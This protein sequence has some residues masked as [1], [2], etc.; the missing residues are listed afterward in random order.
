MAARI[1]RWEHGAAGVVVAAS[2]CGTVCAGSRMHSR[3]RTQTMAVFVDDAVRSIEFDTAIGRVGDVAWAGG[4]VGVSSLAEDD[5]NRTAA[6][7]RAGA[8]ACATGEVCCTVPPC[9]C[10]TY[11]NCLNEQCMKA[12]CEICPAGFICDC[13][14]ACARLEGA[15][16]AQL[17]RPCPAGHFCPF[18]SGSPYPCPAQSY[19]PEPNREGPDSCV[20]CAWPTSS[21]SGAAACSLSLSTILVI[22][23]ACLGA[24]LCVC[25]GGLA[26][27]FLR[28]RRRRREMEFEEQ[29]HAN[30]LKSAVLGQNGKDASLILSYSDVR[31]LCH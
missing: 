24:C 6:G 4:M 29:Q 1:W 16:G 23:G 27:R 5:R 20:P 21:G 26:W 19:N 28:A 31:H 11:I 2:A 9:T 30:A 10:G 13:S 3:T 15:G 12:R 7:R 18:G 8:V 22:T 17:I 25:L 14:A